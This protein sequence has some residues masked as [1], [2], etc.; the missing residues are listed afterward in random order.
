VQRKS[1]FRRLDIW[2]SWL[3][4]PRYFQDLSLYRADPRRPAVIVSSSLGTG[5]TNA[6]KG[7]AIFR[8]DVV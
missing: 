8:V 2:I 7:M 5:A 1:A 4:N 6:V 3:L